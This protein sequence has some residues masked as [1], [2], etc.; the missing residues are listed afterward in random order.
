MTK[1]EKTAGLIAGIS[2]LIMA[3]AAGFS[4][5]FV[6]SELLVES[7]E[8]SKQNILEN[9]N[10]FYASIV[11][12]LLIFI[13]DLMVS[14]AL[15]VFFKNTSKHISMGTATIRLVYTLILGAAIFQLFPILTNLSTDMN[16]LDILGSY[17]SFEKI[18]SFGLIIFGIHLLGLAYLSLKT[19]TVPRFLGYLLYFAGAA[20]TLLHGAKQ[21]SAIPAY[22]I[23]KTEVLLSLPMALSEILL[24]IWLIYRGF[25]RKA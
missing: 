6:Q 2:L 23:E 24:A 21:F 1:Q 12:W 10:L 5:G 25:K 9:S 20:Y 8:I 4:Y 13:T 17:Q 16:A 22:I 19:K 18:W 11:G 15:Y 14:F 7:A 3:I